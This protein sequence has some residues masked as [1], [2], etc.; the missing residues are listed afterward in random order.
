M[1][2]DLQTEIM[3]QVLETISDGYVTGIFC[4]S[5]VQSLTGSPR[6]LL[7]FLN[8]TAILDEATIYQR[9]E[10]LRKMTNGR[11][12]GDAYSVTL[13]RIKSQGGGK[14]R[15][16]MAAL[17]WISRSERPMSPDELCHAIGAQI[18]STEPNPDNIP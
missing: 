5:L 11:S 4:S 16:G 7:V 3:N 6:F 17:I 14:S 15:L 10:Q 8:I 12:L 9:R 18:G 2:A 1:N 13:D